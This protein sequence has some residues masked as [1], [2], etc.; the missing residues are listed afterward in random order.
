[1]TALRGVRIP[2]DELRETYDEVVRVGSQREVARRHEWNQAKVRH[3]VLSYMRHA[4]I[5]GPPPGIVSPDHSQRGTLSHSGQG[6]RSAYREAMAR[7]RELEEQRDALL[8][9]VE[10]LEEVSAMFAGVHRKL[11]RLLAVEPLMV[12][13]DLDRRRVDG[14]AG[15]RRESRSA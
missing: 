8:A 6:D 4:G 9:R 5:E 15:R 13:R 12:P 3:R 1:M 14:G 11:D 2:L 7:V 10:R